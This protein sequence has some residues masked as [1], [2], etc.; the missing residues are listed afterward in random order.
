MAKKVLKTLC[1]FF[2]LP[3]LIFCGCE[4]GGE[5]KALVT[6]F[7]A[8]FT[9]TYRELDVKGSVS[10][11]RQ[12]VVSISI[13]YP[14]TVSGLNISYKDSQMEISRETLICSADEA[15]LPQRSFPS[16]LKL[17]LKGMSDGRAKLISQ[18]ADEYIYNLDTE[19]GNCKITSDKEGRII[20]AE[21]KDSQFYIKFSEMKPSVYN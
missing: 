11:N 20:S 17:I 6:D 10:T 3:V 21:I 16:Q 19:L 14:E 12:G 18:N 13:T 8:D 5:S 7:T 4:S 9:S 15:Y 1:V 2:L